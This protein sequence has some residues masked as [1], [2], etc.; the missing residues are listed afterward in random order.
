MSLFNHERLHAPPRC[1]PVLLSSENLLHFRVYS[2]PVLVDVRFP[3]DHL[4]LSGSLRLDIPKGVYLVS[5]QNVLPPY[6]QRSF[7]TPNTPRRSSL[8][9]PSHHE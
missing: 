3:D 2:L 5:R 8:F 4:S 9:F 6:S 1:F 7:P